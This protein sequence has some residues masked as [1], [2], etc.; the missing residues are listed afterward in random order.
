MDWVNER[1]PL[2]SLLLLF[3]VNS[4][5]LY[6]SLHSLSFPGMNRNAEECHPYYLLILLCGRLW[7]L[8][9]TSLPDP[10]LCG[11]G[12][13]VEPRLPWSLTFW[14]VA[15]QWTLG[16][17]PAEHYFVIVYMPCRLVG[18]FFLPCVFVSLHRSRNSEQFLKALFFH[19]VGTKE[20]S[21]VVRCGSKCPYLLLQLGRSA[22]AALS[23]FNIN[24]LE[25][26]SCFLRGH[27]AV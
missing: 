10:S 19:H 11:R 1:L 14:V 22:R 26:F 15:R 2:L 24:R 13:A 27:G 8:V 6:F 18:S 12:L 17:V 9:C 23:I 5:L 25:V 3:H 16:T 7:P 4:C 21:Q 20:Q